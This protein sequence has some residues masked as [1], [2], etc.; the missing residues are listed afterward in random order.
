MVENQLDQS[1]RNSAAA[2]AMF[3][4]KGVGREGTTVA[5]EDAVKRPIIL[6]AMNVMHEATNAAPNEGRKIVDCLSILPIMRY[7]IRR[8]HA[9][10]VVIPSFCLKRRNS[11]CFL[12]NHFIRELKAHVGSVIEVQH[13]HHDDL[14]ALAIAMETFGSVVSKDKFRDHQFVFRPLSKVCARNIFINYSNDRNNFAVDDGD[15]FYPSSFELARFQTDQ[16]Y[17]LSGS[18]EYELLKE[19]QLSSDDAAAI[20]RKLD[21]LMEMAEAHA[22]TLKGDVDFIS[23]EIAA[24]YDTNTVTLYRVSILLVVGP[25]Y[26]K[27]L[28][29]TN[30]LALKWRAVLRCTSFDRSEKR[31]KKE[32]GSESDHTISLSQKPLKHLGTTSL[33]ASVTALSVDQSA[34][35]FI[36]VL[37]LDFQE[38]R[39]LQYDISND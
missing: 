12:N 5:G 13:R 34:L 6:D 36:A 1:Q 24:E 7:F 35:L 23:E 14:I 38:K 8:G 15:K 9:V 18:E 28:T 4:A 11:S 39:K 31:A 20:V 2:Q 37:Q 22:I 25:A 33:H 27:R 21:I 30:A 26:P 32:C 17:C 19:Q 29:N 16:L 3:S 10:H